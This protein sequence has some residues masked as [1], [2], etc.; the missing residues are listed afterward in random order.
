[1][2]AKVYYADLRAK[3]SNS[4][5]DKTARLLERTGFLGSIGKGDLVAVK[6]HWGE[7]GNVAFLPPPFVRCAVDRIRETGAKPFLT[8]TNTLYAGGRRNAVDNTLTAL[9]NGFSLEAAGAPVV[10]ADGLTG[11]DGVEV[12]VEGGRVAAARIAGAIH[13]ADALL[14]LAH[15][16]GHELYGFG[17]ALK[18]L[19]MGCATPAGKQILHS[20]VRPAVLAERCAGCGACVAVCP[21]GAVRIGEGGAAVIDAAA[22]IGC[23]E[24]TT[25]CPEGAIP[26]NWQTAMRPLVE[27]T[28][29]YVKAVLG[30]KGGRCAFINFV[31]NV[32]PECDC[33]GWNDAPFV[34]DRGIL[35]SLDPVAVDQASADLV[36]RGAALAG[37]KADG[38]A[39]DLI[40]AATGVAD[41][42][43]LLEYAESAGIGT[44]RYDL[45]DCSAPGG[46]AP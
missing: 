25:V 27:K 33:Y 29:D 35:A 23:A 37:S 17:G 12:P 9:K 5:L 10:I 4:I 30:P 7:W 1:M 39:G 16:K 19:A 3:A 32:S 46:G 45:V 31:I 38:A 6:F 44:R 40:A 42:R 43:L 13:H 36:N 14:S 18:N 34:A 26:I 2:T 20:D 24:C 15:F 41:W 28:A 21:A 22:C 8:D 11:H